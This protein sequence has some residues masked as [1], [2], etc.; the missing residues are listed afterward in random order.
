MRDTFIKHGLK[1]MPREYL[2]KLKEGI[3]DEDP[4]Q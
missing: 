4:S 1:N 3:A 2:D